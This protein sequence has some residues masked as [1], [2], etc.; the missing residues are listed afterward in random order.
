[1]FWVVTGPRTRPAVIGEFEANSLTAKV[2]LVDRFSVNATVV[3]DGV[4]TGTV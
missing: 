3:V 1:M 4:M 2:K